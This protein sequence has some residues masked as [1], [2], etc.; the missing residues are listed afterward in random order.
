METKGR[1]IIMARPYGTHE[2]GTKKIK[3]IIE[4]SESSSLSI[5]KIAKEVGVSKSTVEKIRRRYT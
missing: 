2:I 3:K 1:E 4:L 5:R